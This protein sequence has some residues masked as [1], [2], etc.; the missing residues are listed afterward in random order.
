MVGYKL[1][2]L[3]LILILKKLFH[4]I[5]TENKQ[6]LFFIFDIEITFKGVSQSLKGQLVILRMR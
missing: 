3:K 4:E 6:L 2:I 1:E 5:G